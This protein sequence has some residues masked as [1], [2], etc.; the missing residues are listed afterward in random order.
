MEEIAGVVLN[1]G[2]IAQGAASGRALAH[3]IR[4]AEGMCGPRRGLGSAIWAALSLRW[5]R[6]HLAKEGVW[7]KSWK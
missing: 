2:G 4:G 1:Y 3:G 6:F 5:E 7:A